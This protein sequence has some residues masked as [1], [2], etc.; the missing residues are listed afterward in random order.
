MYGLVIFLN[1]PSTW[2]EKELYRWPSRC[3]LTLQP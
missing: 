3:C 2:P 1:F